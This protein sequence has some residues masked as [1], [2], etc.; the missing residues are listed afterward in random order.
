MKNNPI[1]TFEIFFNLD[2]RIIKIIANQLIEIPYVKKLQ[3]N[4]VLYVLLK[5]LK[6]YRKVRV[7]LTF[8]I[9]TVFYL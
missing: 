3:L 6:M 7:I 2:N 1:T 8:L 9:E 5:T 4:S